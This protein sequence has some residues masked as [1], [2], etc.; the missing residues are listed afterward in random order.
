MLNFWPFYVRE[1]WT[2]RLGDCRRVALFGAGEHTGWL[3]DQVQKLPGPK[4]VAIIDDHAD[5]IRE[6]H[7]QAVVKPE[8]AD[9]SNF[10]AVVI[11][12]D[13]NEEKLHHR[14]RACFPQARIVRLYE[15]LPAG[16]Y[17]KQGDLPAGIDT[18]V[19]AD[20]AVNL[21]TVIAAA[22]EVRTK[23]SLLEVFAK[24]DPDEYIGRFCESYRRAI[25]R[26]GPGWKY[27]DLW[28]LLHAYASVAKPKRY[29][30][31]G[32]RRGHSLAAVCGGLP[33][34]ALAELEVVA[35]DLWVTDYAGAENPGPDFVTGQVARL[36]YTRPIRYLSGSSH[37]L[38]PEL[39]G[40]GSETF[41][42]ITVDGDHSR[43]GALADLNHVVGSLRIGGLLVFDDI[44]HPQHPY[45]HEAW[46][47]AIAHRPE[48]ETYTNL[49]D[50]TGT[51][52]AIRFR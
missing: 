19:G 27:L 26:F 30:E 24:L 42:L 10:D 3:L 48:L 22:Q 49:R 38:I 51:A 32:T 39:L 52:A 44:C 47:T 28:S 5:R 21:D 37:E 50:G 8:Q 40:D 15:G 25:D 41:D 14:A 36:G 11:S 46:T 43:D 35:C 34:D 17:E 6:V 12:S 31:I 20:E 9:P 7:G 16:P 13:A 23:E 4:V 2:N 45:L 29:L 1:V 33:P 18:L